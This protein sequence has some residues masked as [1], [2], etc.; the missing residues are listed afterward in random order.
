M[1]SGLEPAGHPKN[2]NESNGHVTGSR[3]YTLV[4]QTYS[5]IISLYRLRAER[6]E[7]VQTRAKDPEGPARAEKTPV[8]I[9]GISKYIIVY[10][11]TYNRW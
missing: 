6:H 7:A 4:Y 5:V 8:K 9:N 11:F 2:G 1:H 3:L 10:R